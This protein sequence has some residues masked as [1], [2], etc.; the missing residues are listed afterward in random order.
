MSVRI[1]K[2]NSQMLQTL[3]IILQRE[4]PS[5]CG[6]VNINA[7][8]TSSDITMAKVY[9][10]VLGDETQ[11]TMAQAWIE[12][13]TKTVQHHLSQELRHMRRVPQ[14]RFIYDEGSQHSIRVTQILDELKRQEEER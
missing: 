11:T 14:L 9:Y 2:V 3:S 13:H 10:G 1:E 8:Q 4:M 7:V 5:E 12:K 6:L